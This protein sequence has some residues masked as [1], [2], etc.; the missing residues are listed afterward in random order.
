VKTRQEHGLK[1]K[2]TEMNSIMVVEGEIFNRTKALSRES[3]PSLV[4]GE[5]Q[6]KEGN[7]SI[8]AGAGLLFVALYLKQRV[9]QFFAKG[10][11]KG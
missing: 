7:Q 3:H 5:R 9:Q 8:A 1:K 11:C 6:A 4:V 2:K 10:L